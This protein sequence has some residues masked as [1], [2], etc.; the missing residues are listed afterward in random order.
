MTYTLFAI[1]LVLAGAAALLAVHA[2]RSEHLVVFS[3]RGGELFVLE[4][5]DDGYQLIERVRVPLAVWHFARKRA[6]ALLR[7]APRVARQHVPGQPL[8]A[9]H[10]GERGART[11]HA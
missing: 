7:A 8:R 10:R 4:R 5:G 1:L 11:A 6:D 3:H 2:F 9:F